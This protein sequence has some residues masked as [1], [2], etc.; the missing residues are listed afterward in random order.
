MREISQ[1]LEE[2]PELLYYEQEVM[3]LVNPAKRT[4][5]PWF[6]FEST[7]APLN[8]VAA[9]LMGGDV[10]MVVQRN[11][12][13]FLTYELDYMLFQDSLRSVSDPRP[14]RLGCSV[15]YDPL[16][17]CVYIFGGYT[18]IDDF[19][20]QASEACEK[21]NHFACSIEPLPNMLQPKCSPAICWHKG[22]VYLCGGYH[23]ER[24]DPSTVAFK[25]VSVLRKEMT[26]LVLF[27]YGGFLYLFDKSKMWK[28]DGYHWE[29]LLRR[30]KG[31]K[32]YS[33]LRPYFVSTVG[34][35][36]YF[37]FDRKC[38]AL[39]M[40]PLKETSYFLESDLES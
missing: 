24:F 25:Q 16:R 13:G 29:P 33:G 21:F 2:Q 27:S 5:K 23:L 11:N 12:T 37:L 1:Y 22:F 32:E 15:L 18:R 34:Q 20:I 40:S 4:K 39:D 35:C 30:S 7:L 6:E 9:A 3:Y 28:S 10:F 8:V 36:C 38:V 31:D 26:W 19:D 14:D 17:S